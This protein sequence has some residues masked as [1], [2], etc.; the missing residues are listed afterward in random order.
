[1]HTA[2]LATIHAAKGDPDEACRYGDQAVTHLRTVE[3]RRVRRHL[4]ELTDR[5]SPHRRVPVAAEFFDHHHGLLVV[6]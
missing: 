6:A 5:L 1:M 2:L 4:T 3:S